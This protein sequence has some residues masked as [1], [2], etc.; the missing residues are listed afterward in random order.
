MARVGSSGWLA[1]RLMTSENKELKKRLRELE[2]R[3]TALTSA[4]TNALPA[5]EE[6]ADDE[7]AFWGEDHSL[8]QDAVKIHEDAKAALANT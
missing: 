3:V 6:N 4:L 2:H 7:C 1:L 5:L 8:A